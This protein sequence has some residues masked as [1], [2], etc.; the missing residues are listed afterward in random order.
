MLGGLSTPGALSA[1][2]ARAESRDQA[3]QLLQ[4]RLG[5]SPTAALYLLDLRIAALAPY[6][7]DM[8]E[9]ELKTLSNR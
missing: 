8:L 3:L 1:L 2:L 7:Q 5:L 4:S 6:Y 9:E